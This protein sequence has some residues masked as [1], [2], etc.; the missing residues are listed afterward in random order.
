[1]KLNKWV[2][3]VI[4]AVLSFLAGIGIMF[5]IYM[6][7]VVRRVPASMFLYRRGFI[8]GIVLAIF[9]IILGFSLKGYE[10]E[11]DETETSF[12]ELINELRQTI[13]R[14]SESPEVRHSFTDYLKSMWVDDSTK[15]MVERALKEVIEEFKDQPWLLALY[16]ELLMGDGRWA[17][18]EVMIKRAWS[19][20]PKDEYVRQIVRQWINARTS[21]DPFRV[22]ELVRALREVY[23]EGW[24]YLLE[25][26]H[27]LRIGR[28]GRI[29]DVILEAYRLSDDDIKLLEVISAYMGYLAADGEEERLLS[30]FERLKSASSR[31]LIYAVEAK[32]AALMG[33][34]DRAVSA[35][36]K[37]RESD[38]PSELVNSVVSDIMNSARADGKDDIVEK[39]FE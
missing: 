20:D 25:A 16:A 21:K 36:K 4:S 18:A 37:L 38:L 11:E 8:I 26:E 30:F 3:V 2:Y 31:S 27:M 15:V 19:A 6:K 9:M 22:S 23:P 39:L 14:A 5:F 1:M 10:T 35:I 28:T 13:K 7:E 32:M 33:D 17:D 29:E 12:T 34:Y 24:L